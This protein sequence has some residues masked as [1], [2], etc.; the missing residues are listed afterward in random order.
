MPQP[1]KASDG[2][3]H[4]AYELLLMNA[5]ALPVRV[6]RWRVLDASTHRVLLK[7]TGAALKAQFIPVGTPE[8]DVGAGD[9]ANRARS[10]TMPCS[11]TWVV[12]LNVTQATIVDTPNRNR[13]MVDG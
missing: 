10:T 8:G 1:F 4:L 7:L 9:P 11:A 2:R 12:W 13:N 3:I 6:G 5:T